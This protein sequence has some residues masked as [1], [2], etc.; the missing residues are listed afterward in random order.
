M[1]ASVKL[2]IALSKPL[3]AVRH[4]Q[5]QKGGGTGRGLLGGGGRQ[6]GIEQITLRAGSPYSTVSLMEG[7]GWA[8][9]HACARAKVDLYFFSIGI[10]S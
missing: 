3:H 10:R 5:E 7:S 6:V 1:H 9:A 2:H 4:A 8:R